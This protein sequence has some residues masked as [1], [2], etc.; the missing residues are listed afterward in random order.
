MNEGKKVLA[1]SQDSR[2]DILSGSAQKFQSIV[3]SSAPKPGEGQPLPSPPAAPTA[4]VP[5]GVRPASCTLASAQ[6]CPGHDHSSR[7]C[8]RGLGRVEARLKGVGGEDRETVGADSVFTSLALKGRR[9][10]GW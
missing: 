1:H 6:P 9:E 8:L 2:P 7:I 4:R 10:L 5:A 3:C